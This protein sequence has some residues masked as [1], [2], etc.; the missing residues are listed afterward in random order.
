MSQNNNQVNLIVREV[1]GNAGK[2]AIPLDLDTDEIKSL[3]TGPGSNWQWAILE[4]TT[5]PKLYKLTTTENLGI[6]KVYIIDI[7][8]GSSQEIR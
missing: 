1:S 5:P 2:K 4:P 6:H 8:E 3:I 7:V